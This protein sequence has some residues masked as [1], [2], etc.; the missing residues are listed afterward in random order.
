M[1]NWIRKVDQ[2][3]HQRQWLEVEG[4]GRDGFIFSSVYSQLNDLSF[5]IALFLQGN[6]TI[7]LLKITNNENLCREKKLMFRPLRE[8]KS[9]IK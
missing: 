6:N 3:M 1:S 5:Q 9:G 8:A 2:T 4:Q 7:L